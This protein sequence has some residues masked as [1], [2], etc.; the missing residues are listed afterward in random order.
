MTDEEFFLLLKKIKTTS[1]FDEIHKYEDMI[2]KDMYCSFQYAKSL[3]RRFEKGE[4]TISQS[5]KLSFLYAKEILKERFTDGEQEIFSNIDLTYE[6]VTSFIKKP[7]EEVHIKL[8]N[9]KWQ[10]DYLIFL[11][12]NGYE[13]MTLEYLI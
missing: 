5:S 13:D 1:D 6:Y 10:K 3:N 8:L 7:I 11:N 9:S 2:A 4:K 12:E